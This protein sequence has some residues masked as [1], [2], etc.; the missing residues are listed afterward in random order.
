M[1]LFLKQLQIM[2]V[3]H[4]IAKKVLGSALLSRQHVANRIVSN[5][6]RLR[7]IG[8]RGATSRIT[9]PLFVAVNDKWRRSVPE[10]RSPQGRRNASKFSYRKPGIKEQLDY[11]RN[12]H[13][14]LRGYIDQRTVYELHKELVSYS[15]HN[16]LD[17]WQQKVEVVTG[18]REL[19]VLIGASVAECQR[20]LREFIPNMSVPF[21]QYF[22]TWRSVPK[23]FEVC[24]SLSEA[25]SILLHVPSV[26]LY[27]D[28]LFWKR[29]GRDGATPWHVDARMAPFDTPHILTFWIPLHEVEDS[30]LIFCSR[31]HSDFALPYWHP[32]SGNDGRSPRSDSP[33][34]SLEQRYRFNSI[35][36]YM[37]LRAGDAT[38]H[39]G[40][41]LHCADPVESTSDRFALAISYVD[42]RAPI[43]ANLAVDL[44]KHKVSNN[45]GDK[46]DAWSYKDWINDVPTAS[47]KWDHELVPILWPPSKRTPILKKYT[48]PIQAW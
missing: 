26:R 43:R 24:R 37:P 20:Q 19:P 17:A 38:V 13:A 18:G 35:V 7:C 8:H 22:N 11:A 34:N 27:Q 4:C 6:Q 10:E 44:T 39:S 33:W 30:G 42:A 3:Y 12:G 47:D 28:A 14:V 23:V 16:E 1:V 36:D 21:L 40:W 48:N 41:T 46:E 31:T 29:K 9:A 2:L 25:A 32:Y 15:L 5:H 45:Y